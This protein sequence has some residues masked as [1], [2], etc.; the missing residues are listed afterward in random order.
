MDG[1]TKKNF[2]DDFAGRR[3]GIEGVHQKT[4][5]EQTPMNEQPRSSAQPAPRQPLAT[6]GKLAV[7]RP[8][9]NPANVPSYFRRLR[10]DFGGF[11]AYLF[12]WYRY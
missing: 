6:Q 9:A 8:P 7:H 3:L 12:S 2:S 4:A 10:R 11:I 1:T 5:L